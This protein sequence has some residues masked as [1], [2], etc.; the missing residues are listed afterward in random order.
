MQLAYIGDIAGLDALNF[1]LFA[2]IITILAVIGA[3]NAFNMVDGIDGLLGGLA[4]ITF[5]D[6]AVV[7]NIHALDN[8]AFVCMVI[9]T[10]L[11]PYVMMNMGVF[12]HKRK[13]FMGDAGSM[14]IGFIVIWFLLT[15]TQPDASATIRPVTGLRLIA[16]PLMD[17]TV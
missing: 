4:I 2:P 6:M 1:G 5:T 12:G 17:M 7:L 9:V 13:I 15:M 10:A 8:L 16:L 11:V 3:I 14:M